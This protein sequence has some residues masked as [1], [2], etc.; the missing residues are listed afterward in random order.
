LTE[1]L[2]HARIGTLTV[3]LLTTG[4]E[5]FA[6]LHHPVPQLAR[7]LLVRLAPLRQRR[8]LGEIPRLPIG[9]CAAGD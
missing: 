3:D 6:D 5:S 9:L 4:K 7:P 2:T 1:V 8:L